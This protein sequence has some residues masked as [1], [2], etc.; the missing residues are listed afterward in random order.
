MTTKPYLFYWRMINQNFQQIPVQGM[1]EGYTLVYGN[2]S[3]D[4]LRIIDKE[5]NV[6]TTQY[7]FRLATIF[8]SENLK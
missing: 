1:T 3:A 4:A 5:F 6:P 2:D 8:L 7:E